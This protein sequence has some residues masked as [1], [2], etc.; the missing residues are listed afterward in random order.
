M[1]ILREIGT[2][3]FHAGP[4]APH[5]WRPEALA[6]K[7]GERPRLLKDR[8]A[9]MEKAGIIGAYDVLP[10]PITLGLSL[11]TYALRA[12]SLAS[13]VGAMARLRRIHGVLGVVD[14]L[15]EWINVALAFGDEKELAERLAAVQ[16]ALGGAKAVVYFEP[17]R[18]RPRPPELTRTDWRIVQALRGDAKKPLN[19][20]AKSLGV[21]TKT[22]QR[23]LQKI[24]EQGA[25]DSFAQLDARGFEE[26]FFAAVRFR[27]SM[28][29]VMPAMNKLHGELLASAWV[30][31][32]AEPLVDD[33]HFDLIV[34]PRSPKGLRDLVERASKIPGVVEVEGHVATEIVWMPDWID[35][36]IAARIAE[37]AAAAPKR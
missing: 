33:A 10:D 20:L 22:V 36:Q 19:R 17:P 9:R 5:P 11:R 26:V 25:I 3:P 21:T 1:R 15:D 30:Q 35:A 16:A 24:S 8:L 18:D 29:D 34:A 7:L 13:K 6:A 37:M 32:S 2:E 23:R 12:P 31:C 4:R 27:V 14:F 28:P